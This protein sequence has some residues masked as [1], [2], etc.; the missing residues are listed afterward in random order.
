MTFSDLILHQ[1]CGARLW[2]IFGLWTYQ[3]LRCAREVPAVV[4]HPKQP[5]KEAKR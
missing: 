4:I 3:C 5:T 1:T 2:P